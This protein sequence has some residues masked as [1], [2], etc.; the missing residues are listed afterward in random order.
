M[1]VE[2]KQAVKNWLFRIS[3]LAG[4][5]NAYVQAE[6][7]NQAFNNGKPYPWKPMTKHFHTFR[8]D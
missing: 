4:C 2:M 7:L 5:F 3:K 6:L 8:K 1:R